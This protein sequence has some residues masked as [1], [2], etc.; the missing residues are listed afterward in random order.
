MTTSTTLYH[1]NPHSPTRPPPT[2]SDPTLLCIKDIFGHQSILELLPAVTRNREYGIRKVLSSGKVE[3]RTPRQVASFAHLILAAP[4]KRSHLVSS[5]S[6]ALPTFLPEDLEGAERLTQAIAHLTELR[7]LDLLH[8]EAGLASYPPLINAF[9]SLRSVRV[10]RVSGAD[11]WTN[12]LLRRLQAGLQELYLY[13]GAFWGEG[14]DFVML[15]ELYRFASSLRKLVVDGGFTPCLPNANQSHFETASDTAVEADVELEGESD[16]GYDA[17]NESSESVD[18]EAKSE[19]GSASVPVVVG[20]STETTSETYTQG[21]PLVL[22]ADV[23]NKLMSV[24]GAL[25]KSREIYAGNGS[26]SEDEGTGDE[27]RKRIKAWAANVAYHQGLELNGEVVDDND[28]S[29]DDAGSAASDVEWVTHEVTGH[30]VFPNLIYLWIP[31]PARGIPT[32][33]TMMATPGIIFLDIGTTHESYTG[34]LRRIRRANKFATFLAS[35][36][37]QRWPNLQEV[38]GSLVDL[39][40]FGN[41]TTTTALEVVGVIDN[42]NL[43]L[44]P[45]VVDDHNPMILRATI[46]IPC[47]SPLR[48]R[49][50]QLPEEVLEEAD[51]MLEV[52]HLTLR[53]VFKNNINLLALRASLLRILRTWGGLLQ[54][55]IDLMYDEEDCRSA[56]PGA[57]DGVD[58]HD[59]VRDLAEEMGEYYQILYIRQ[60]RRVACCDTRRVVEGREVRWRVHVLNQIETREKEQEMQEGGMFSAV[61]PL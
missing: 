18:D 49:P 55:F 46:R 5:L 11:E 54:V 37:T 30:R 60:G 44:L 16:A 53:V 10:L 56:G 20:P 19:V 61:Y 21:V 40:V 43:Q 42:K 50:D 45:A 23:F 38:R 41:T 13:R 4:Q 27:D 25:E 47:K 35:K 51:S 15:L 48:R 29:Q 2:V 57:L 36:K 14:G 3:L 26:P 52:H 8:P 31:D 1:P 28:Y 34:A 7:E 9:R 12:R 32:T 39:A 22:N 33:A 59:L 24:G 17:D 6:I 58:L